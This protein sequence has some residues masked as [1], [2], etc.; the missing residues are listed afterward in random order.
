MR[1]IIGKKIKMTQIPAIN[2]ELL[3]PVTLIK[4]GPCYVTQIKHKNKDGYTAVQIGFEE[5]KK[6]TKP[7]EGHLKKANKKLRFLKEF[8][9]PPEEINN[10]FKVGNLINISIFK[11]GDKVK[12]TSKSKG[13]GFQG[14]VKRWHF[15]GV[16]KTH[17]TKHA[18]RQ[19]G[20]IGIGGHQKVMKGKKM[21][22]RTGNKTIT[23]N[24]LEILSIDEK[25]NLI[26]V[27]GA[28]PGHRNTIVTIQTKD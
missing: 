1:F 4:A 6:L 8:K 17:G 16:S 15:R 10:K 23:I 11:P 22:G 25:N 20:S 9:L 3:V 26:A 21:P 27:K 5:A 18:H 7:L 13:K 19:P 28:V 2:S 14:V 24:N 12:V